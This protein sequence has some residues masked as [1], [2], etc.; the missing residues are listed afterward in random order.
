MSPF[1]GDGN[2]TAWMSVSAD[3]RRAIVG[4]YR[5]L[6]RP[7]PGPRFCGCV[8]SIRSSVPDQLWPDPDDDSV[9]DGVTSAAATS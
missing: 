8:G 4:W 3:R 1:E 6:N 2:E 9:L 7:P 5:V